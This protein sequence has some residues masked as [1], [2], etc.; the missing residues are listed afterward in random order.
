MPPLAFGGRTLHHAGG[1][2]FALFR[3]QRGR[4]PELE[5]E[6]TLEWLG[7]FLGRLHA[8]GQRAAYRARPALDPRSFG[9]EPRDWIVASDWLP[10]EV[11][12]SWIDASTRALE[13]VQRV[14]QGAGRVRSLRLHGDCHAGNL[15]W[16]EQGP[17]FV[18]FDDSRSGP[19]VQDLWMLLSGDP[20]QAR[21][22][23]CALLRGYRM[24][25]EFDPRELQLVEAL[26]TLRLLHYSAW[27]ARRWNDPAFPAGFP[28]F[29]DARYW[30]QRV[31][32]LRDQVELM[33]QPPPWLAPAGLA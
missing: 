3:R 28:W 10:P 33:R 31:V 7:R 19:A 16:S 1:H 12:A 20:A 2:R 13:E 9:F 18:D 8:V 14:W 23:L 29:G 32:E 11:R 4:A 6:Q 22:Q 30:Q 24:F 17:Y 21:E 26:R 27:I 25:A 15:Q 5:Q